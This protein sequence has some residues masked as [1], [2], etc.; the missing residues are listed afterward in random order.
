M[1]NSGQIFAIY[2][3]AAVA[4]I[5][6]CFAVWAWL[7]L[8]A[9]PLWLVPGL[10]LLALFAALLTL[11]PAE[12]AGR[13][14]AAYGGLYIVTSLWWMWAVEGQMP[15]RWDILGGALCLLGASVILFAPRA[16]GKGSDLC[17]N[18]G[19]SLRR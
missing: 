9:S 19:G 14:F 11:S 10:A 18:L 5:G 17:S 13:A 2:V 1:L 7:R 15:D 8:G 12:V 6:G 3:A 4:E 16:A